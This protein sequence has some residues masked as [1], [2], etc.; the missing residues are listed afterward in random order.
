MAHVQQRHHEVGD[1]GYD[2]V[3]D[4]DL[5]GQRIDVIAVLRSQ[6]ERIHHADEPPEDGHAHEQRNDYAHRDGAQVELVDLTILVAKD[7]HVGDGAC[8]S[9]D[10]RLGEQVD[11][12]DE[13]GDR[14]PCDDVH[15]VAIAVFKLVGN[16]VGICRGVVG[17][18]V[19][20]VEVERLVGE[21]S[22]E[23]ALVLAKHPIE[24]VDAHVHVGRDG[25]RGRPIN[26]DVVGVARRAVGERGGIAERD[27]ALLKQTGVCNDAPAAHVDAGVV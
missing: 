5:Q 27:A 21:I 23:V 9:V 4:N 15:D 3:D 26:R 1:E 24:R 13:D 22:V 8:A 25:K 10:E 19:A 12:D 20:P 16:L 7:L 18:K 17:R 14:E 6:H 11:D 2:K